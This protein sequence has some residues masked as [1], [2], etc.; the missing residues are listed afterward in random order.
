MSFTLAGMLATL[1]DA[2]QSEVVVEDDVQAEETATEVAEVAGEVAADEA[3]IER[4][5]DVIDNAF[6]AG[7]ELQV[8]QGKAEESLVG[9]GETPAEGE[10]GQE[11]EGLSEGEATLIEITHESIMG[12][13]GMGAG[14]VKR[15]TP[16]SF[17]KSESKRQVTMEALDGLK[18]SGAKVYAGI[19]AA[20]KAAWNTVSNFIVGLLRNRAVL[21]KHLTNLEGKV[22]AIPADLKPRAASFKTA[23]GALSINGKASVDTAAE[24]LSTAAKAVDVLKSLTAVV[25]RLKSE[26]GD[27]DAQAEVKKVVAQLGAGNSEGGKEAFGHFTN[28]RSLH[29]DENGSVSFTEGKKAEEIEAPSINNMTV[30][31]NRAKAVIS[32]LRVVEQTNSKFKAVV[33]AITGQLSRA[34]NAVKSKVG[35]DESKEAA[36]VKEKARVAKSL[37]SKAGGQLPAAIF[38]AAKAIADYVTAGINNYKPEAKAAQ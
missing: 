27:A 35:S 21:E 29:A 31:L 36:K 9:E 7:D 4:A 32:Q 2:S 10:L 22:K 11:G 18:E 16:E 8:L 24:I 28:A 15:Y 17:G 37:V 20:L 25:D 3:S 23:A 1:E 5:D 34:A 6:E 30:L 33:E 12:K 14:Q 26:T 19:I 13:L 38:A